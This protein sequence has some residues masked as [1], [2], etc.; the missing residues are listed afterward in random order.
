MYMGV[1]RGGHLIFRGTCSLPMT[2]QKGNIKEKKGRIRENYERKRRKERK[3]AEFVKSL[4]FKH[5]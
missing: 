5:F 3:K 2:L 4:I 1:F